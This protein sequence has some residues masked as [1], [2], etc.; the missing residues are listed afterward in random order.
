ML[1]HGI[2]RINVSPRI[3]I[4][5]LEAT[6]SSSVR[7]LSYLLPSLLASILL[8][9]PKFLEARL[10]TVTYVEDNVTQSSVMINVTRLRVD[11][12]YSYYYIGWTR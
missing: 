5:L 8:N 3:V 12:H 4:V 10:E 6:Y 7:L 9:L 1:Y 11:P 2:V